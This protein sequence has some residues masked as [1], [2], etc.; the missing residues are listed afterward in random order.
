MKRYG[1]F[2]SSSLLLHQRLLQL[3]EQ[4]LV[5]SFVPKPPLAAANQCLGLGHARVVELP[6]QRYGDGVL[7][8]ARRVALKQIIGPNRDRDLLALIHV[9]YWQSFDLHH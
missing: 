7:L 6:T 8:G 5:R 4:P 2:V 1:A 3:L 9:D